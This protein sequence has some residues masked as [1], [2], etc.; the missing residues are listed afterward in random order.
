M[1]NVP[2]QRRFEIRA[3]RKT[4][5]KQR[6]TSSGDSR[7]FPTAVNQTRNKSLPNVISRKREASVRSS[8]SSVMNRIFF[9]L[10]QFPCGRTPSLHLAAARA[11]ASPRP[12]MVS[13]STSRQLLLLL[14]WESGTLLSSASI[15][16]THSYPRPEESPRTPT[17]VPYGKNP[18]MENDNKANQRCS[19]FCTV[20]PP[21]LCSGDS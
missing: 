1:H 3:T 18:S 19:S 5:N 15:A 11:P 20:T 8:F 7:G 14:L 12:H 17:S 13:A 9:S 16:P 4:R 6:V 10:R 21:L 2:L